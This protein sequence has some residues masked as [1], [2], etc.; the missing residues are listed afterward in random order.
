M[1]KMNKISVVSLLVVIS[2]LI[3]V[4]QN[5]WLTKLW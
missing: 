2:V 4:K 3:E 1:A 5:Y